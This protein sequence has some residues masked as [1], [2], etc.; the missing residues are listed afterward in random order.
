MA[1]SVLAIGF[2]MP[3]AQSVPL[4]GPSA[5]PGAAIH[6]VQMQ[7]KDQIAPGQGGPRQLTPQQGG[8]GMS[9]GGMQGQMQGPGGERLQPGERRG[10]GP[11]TGQ[12][13]PQVWIGREHHGYGPHHGRRGWEGGR[14]YGYLSGCGWLRERALATGSRHWWRRY[15]ECLH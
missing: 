14:G 8:P 10:Y 11:Q 1:A 6:K 4:A 15:R 12:R 13:R 9:P 7:Q 2:G 3:P 5:S